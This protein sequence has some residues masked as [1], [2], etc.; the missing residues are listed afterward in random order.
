MDPEPKGEIATKDIIGTIGETAIRHE[1]NSIELI[2]NF[3][4][5]VRKWSR[6]LWPLP[7]MSSAC[8]LPVE[9]F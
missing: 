1:D 5:L 4:I 7:L 2:F 6:T 8:L 9:K 3:L